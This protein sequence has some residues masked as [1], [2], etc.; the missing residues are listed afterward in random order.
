MPKLVRA[1]IEWAVNATA[2]G[3][4]AVAREPLEESA[5]CCGPRDQILTRSQM[6]ESLPR[7]RETGA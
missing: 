2:G 5:A 6:R 3:E 4:A 1:G 7:F